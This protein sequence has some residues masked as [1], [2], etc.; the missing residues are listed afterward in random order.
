[1]RNIKNAYVI[2]NGKPEGKRP[3][4][5]LMCRWE[6]TIKMYLKD[7]DLGGVDSIELLSTN[8]QWQAF[9]N[10]SKSLGPIKGREFLYKVSKY[11]I[12]NEDCDPCN[13]LVNRLVG[14]LVGWLVSLLSFL[15]KSEDRDNWAHY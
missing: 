14:W 15:Q 10:T 8:I 2:L 1:M 12:L 9:V 13:C 3:L 11:Q 6:D 5:R 7:I 4:W